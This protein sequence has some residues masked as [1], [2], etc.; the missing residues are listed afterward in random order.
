MDYEKVPNIII[1]KD[2]DYLSDAFNWNYGAYKSSIN[3]SDMVEDDELS[4]HLDKASEVFHKGMTTITSILAG[5]NN[6]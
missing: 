2:L 3:A 6:E 1:G 5:G 4:E